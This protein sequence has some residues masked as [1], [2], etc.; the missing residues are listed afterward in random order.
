M[1]DRVALVA[2]A[3]L[4]IL[5]GHSLAGL[6]WSLLPQSRQTPPTSIVNIGAA[7]RNPSTPEYQRIAQLS[8]FGKAQAETARATPI[9]APDTRLDL[10]LR[11]ILFNSDDEMARAIIASTGH[12]DEHFRT[13][14]QVR[15]G[16]TLDRIYPDR[17]ILLREG[18]YETLRLPEERLEA[19]ADAPRRPQAAA[20]RPVR[21]A[22]PS[23]AGPLGGIGTAQVL[24][25]YRQQLVSQPE[26]AH[27]FI[28]AEPVNDGGG[29]AGF[30]ISPGADTRLFEAAGLQPGDIVTAVNDIQLDAL[31]KG[32]L[33]M[34]ELAN[35]SQLSVTVLRGG[36]QQTI[37]LNFQ[38]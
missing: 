19:S 15:P 21:G 28:R 10:T 12:P 11:G 14:Q 36:Q 13:G 22:S 2:A 35:A 34:E 16:V 29:L 38:Q 26:N 18:Q 23:M 8:L 25:Q 37:Q 3:V 33:A 7:V 9:D 5:L 31:D 32:F 30:R 24:N 6:T 4:V 27:Q 17:V 20:R 1:L